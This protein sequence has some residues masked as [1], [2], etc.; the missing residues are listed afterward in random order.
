MK[1]QLYSRYR[2][3]AGQ[4]VRTA[5]NIKGIDYEYIPVSLDGGTP[6]SYREEVNPQA[7]LPTLVVDGELITQSTAQIEYIEE[8]FEGPSLFPDDPI[9][10]ARSRAFSQGIACDIHPVV[11]PKLQRK[12]QADHGFSKSDVLAWYQY[13]QHHGF[14]ALEKLLA[15]RPVQTPFC[16]DEKPTVADIYLVPQLFN[17]RRVNVDLSPYPLIR[18]IDERCRALPAFD[19]AM[20]EKQPDWPGKENAR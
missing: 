11:G 15:R 20:P 1:I 3:S 8:M 7:L 6:E 4:R 12:F 17:A 16:Y 19:A 5:L 9:D 18:E 14:E 13:W 2:N 10:R